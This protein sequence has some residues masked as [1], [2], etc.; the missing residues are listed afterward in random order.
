MVAFLFPSLPL[1][2]IIQSTLHPLPTASHVQN[3]VITTSNRTPYNSDTYSWNL[4]NGFVQFDTPLQIHMN[5]RENREELLI[6]SEPTFLGRYVVYALIIKLTS[7]FLSL[8]SAIGFDI[9][10][11]IYFFFAVEAAELYLHLPI[12]QIMMTHKV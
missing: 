12:N 3:T 9:I 5:T 10:I 11:C 7:R 8:R 6:L 2:A 1:V 4:P